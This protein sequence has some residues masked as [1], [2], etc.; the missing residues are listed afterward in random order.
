MSYSAQVTELFWGAP[1]HWAW[2]GVLAVAVDSRL[3]KRPAGHR[4]LRLGNRL[5]T[6]MWVWTSSLINAKRSRPTLGCR[7]LWSCPLLNQGDWF[8]TLQVG[9]QQAAMR[10]LNAY[11]VA[12][13]I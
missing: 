6:I 1:R 11:G 12:E 5:L 4:D 7:D 10:A 13:E 9:G 2:P 8:E 3:S